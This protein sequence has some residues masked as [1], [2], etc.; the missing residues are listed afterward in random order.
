MA[1]Y[2]L[3][4]EKNSEPDWE[5]IK[6]GNC[7]DLQK[8]KGIY[9][10]LS[11]VWNEVGTKTNMEI[12]D[13]EDSY[14]QD[15]ELIEFHRIVQEELTK[16]RA[17]QV[18]RWEFNLHTTYEG[19][20]GNLKYTPSDFDS[21]KAYLA[22]N[23]MKSYEYEVREAQRDNLIINSKKNW[24]KVNKV[25]LIEFLKQLENKLSDAITRDKKVYLSYA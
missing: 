20:I 6:W 18:D 23:F 14:F 5:S 16:S 7:F 13:I 15:D 3:I 12:S 1:I 4:A 22:E 19:R 17:I 24:I 25:E 21:T 10:H 2:V 11:T 8:N 9:F